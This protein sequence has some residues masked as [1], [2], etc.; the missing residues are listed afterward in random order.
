MLSAL[1]HDIDHP[2]NNNLFEIN[3]KLILAQIYNNINVLENYNCSLAF[4]LINLPTIQLLKNLSTENYNKVRDLIISCIMVTD[5]KSHDKLLLLLNK[6]EKWYNNYKLLC[7]LIIHLAD[8]SNQLRPYEI[9]KLNSTR[10]RIE[11]SNQINKELKL[12][13]PITKFI[14]VRDDENFYKIEF[15]F[16]TNTIKPLLKIFVLKFPEFNYILDQLDSNIKKWYTLL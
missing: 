12:K 3:S 13:L 7:K 9:T 10:M 14:D 15:D 4:K 16:C 2:G 1:V 8:L 11:F 6:N 5:M